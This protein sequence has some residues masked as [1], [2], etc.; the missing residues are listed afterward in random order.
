[1]NAVAASV[2]SRSRLHFILHAEQVKNDC[3][4][5]TQTLASV[6]RLRER[7]APAIDHVEART[8]V[9]SHQRHRQSSHLFQTRQAPRCCPLPTSASRHHSNS[10]FPP[11]LAHLRNIN[12]RCYNSLSKLALYLLTKLTEISSTNWPAVQI[13]S[14]TS[15]KIY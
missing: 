11:Q 2:H 8:V 14:E 4:N 12:I 15:R 6:G 10:L 7:E 9:S 13:S 5:T 3:W 1:M